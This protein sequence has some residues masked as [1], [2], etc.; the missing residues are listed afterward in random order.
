MSIDGRQQFIDG[1]K[2]MGFS[3]AMVRSVRLQP[4]AGV[5]VGLIGAPG[6]AAR[7]LIECGLACR[8]DGFAKGFTAGELVEESAGEG[9]G[10]IVVDR[11]AGGHDAAH[12]H[13]DELA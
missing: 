6:I 5:A 3:G 7:M 9:A 10:R 11:P 13:L 2:G 12:A 4:I 8:E 1:D